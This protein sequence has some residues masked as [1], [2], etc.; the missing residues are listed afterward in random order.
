MSLLLL[1]VSQEERKKPGTFTYLN[2]KSDCRLLWDK[3]MRIPHVPQLP[4]YLGSTEVTLSSLM[5]SSQCSYRC[6]H[7][8]ICWWVGYHLVYNNQCLNTLPGAW[9]IS[10]ILQHAIHRLEN[11]TAQCIT[12][13]T[14]CADVNIRTQET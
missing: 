7:L 3:D 10:L 9:S 1:L 2:N 12:I 11:L 8:S 5:A 14:I 13:A 4:A 6:P